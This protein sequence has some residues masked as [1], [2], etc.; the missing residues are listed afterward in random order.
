[1]L[2]PHRSGD[3]VPGATGAPAVGQPGLPPGLLAIEENRPS[4]PGK[5]QIG[6]PTP[7][8]NQRPG[9]APRGGS[10]RASSSALGVLVGILVVLAILAVL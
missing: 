2:T 10:Q 6:R 1:M 3:S 8:G 5:P 9:S 7:A 4:A